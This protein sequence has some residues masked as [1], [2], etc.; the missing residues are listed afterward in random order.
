M[1]LL[2]APLG[3][4]GARIVFAHL[5]VVAII[6]TLLRSGMK[7]STVWENAQAERAAGIQAPAISS[8]FPR[9]PPRRCSS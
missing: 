4:L 5:A 1:F 6:L 8:L 9:S 7:E 2:M 3:L